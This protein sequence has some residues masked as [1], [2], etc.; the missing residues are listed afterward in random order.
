M[1]V[2][3]NR[4]LEVDAVA[5]APEKTACAGLDVSMLV[6]LAVFVAIAICAVCLVARL[7]EW[8]QG[9]LCGTCVCRDDPR[10]MGDG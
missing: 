5:R 8:R 9:V 2:M 4:R 3:V 6:Y 10:Q 1:P 7:Y